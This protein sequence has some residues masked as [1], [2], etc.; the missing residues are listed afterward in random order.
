MCI[1]DSCVDCPNPVAS[2]YNTTEYTLSVYYGENCLATNVVTVKV[3][4]EP[5]FY[6]PNAFS[7]NGD[8]K[9]DRIFLYGSG[10]VSYTH[11]DVYKRQV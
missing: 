10:S 5:E 7:P 2:P 9:N 4:R 11:L 6:M 3:G 8:S 1:R